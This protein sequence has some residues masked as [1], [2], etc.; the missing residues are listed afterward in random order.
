MDAFAALY[1]RYAQAIHAFAYRRSGSA[2]VADDVTSSTFEAAL[3][4]MPS[5]RWRGGGFKAWLYRIAA[6]QTADAH[7][8]RHREHVTLHAGPEPVA[9]GADEPVLEGLDAD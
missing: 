9:P 8:A 4:R 3:R 5:F 1:R 6:A 2:T 7:R